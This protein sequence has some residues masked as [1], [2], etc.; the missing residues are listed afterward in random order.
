[1]KKETLQFELTAIADAAAALS[2]MAEDIDPSGE[3][4]ELTRALTKE[5]EEHLATKADEIASSDALQSMT[6]RFKGLEADMRGT[7]GI[8]THTRE[9]LQ[10]A[11]KECAE[12]T[13]AYTALHKQ[14][15]Y[16]EAKIKTL[17]SQVAEDIKVAST[18]RNR[19]ATLEDASVCGDDDIA[20]LRTAR[21][22]PDHIP[23]GTK[24]WRA[25]KG[26]QSMH[27]EI[28][29]A[30]NVKVLSDTMWVYY[31]L[32]GESHVTADSVFVEADA[33]QKYLERK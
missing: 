30:I 4:K 18:L 17:D 6:K 15:V 9:S 3:I 22:I 2:R 8:L 32:D 29:R 13:E 20:K 1:M 7:M 16:L 21:P 27:R 5:I 28:V 26:T 12:L 24:V 14:N 33:A 19:I 23:A 31:D 25:R 10:S 11:E